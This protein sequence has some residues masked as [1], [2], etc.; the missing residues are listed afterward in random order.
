MHLIEN[1][2]IT[3]EEDA[4]NLIIK[5][6][7]QS[8]NRRITPK[9]KLKLLLEKE[10]RLVGNIERYQAQ[11]KEIRKEIPILRSQMAAQ[12]FLNLDV[13][14]FIKLSDELEKQDIQTSQILMFLAEGNFEK[15]HEIYES[16]NDIEDKS[17]NETKQNLED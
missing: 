8:T 10:K 5:N 13:N 11:L 3:N 14:T 16:L 9:E 4:A 15:L 12:D 2:K 6:K 17:V 7:P 1:D